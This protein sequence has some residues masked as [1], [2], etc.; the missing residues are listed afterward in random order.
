MTTPM[1][2]ATSETS[3]GTVPAS[4]ADAAPSP[5][6]VTPPVSAVD[7]KPLHLDLAPERGHIKA[8]CAKISEYVTSKLHSS[9]H[10]DNLENIGRSVKSANLINDAIP[11][12]GKPL[13]SWE[14]VLKGAPTELADYVTV[15]G[16]AVGRSLKDAA[17]RMIAASKK[18]DDG[19]MRIAG[20]DL[21][22]LDAERRHGLSNE[23]RAK[24]SGLYRSMTGEIQAAQA[25]YNEAGAS[26]MTATA[27]MDG[28]LKVDA[29]IREKFKGA[30]GANTYYGDEDLT[31]LETKGFTGL[32][33]KLVDLYQQAR[34]LVFERLVS[35]DAVKGQ[36][37][38]GIAAAAAT[39]AEE[40]RGIDQ[41]MVNVINQVKVA[42]SVVDHNRATAA[43]MTDSSLPSDVNAS[44]IVSV[45][46]TTFD[47]VKE[48]FDRKAA[49]SEKK[50]AEALPGSATKEELER[51][52]AATSSCA[53]DSRQFREMLQGI[54][55]AVQP[56]SALSDPA[57]SG[58]TREF[59][60]AVRGCKREIEKAAVAA[61]QSLPYDEA[62]KRFAVLREYSEKVAVRATAELASPDKL[63]GSEAVEIVDGLRKAIADLSRKSWV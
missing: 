33:G 3:T 56:V 57:L 34:G 52:S 38:K 15:V 17:S 45:S 14:A 11:E 16:G 29:T 22:G 44:Q 63:T 58:A 37:A 8:L 46:A 24:I 26:I 31:A 48:W 53:A 23:Q 28:L 10:L 5:A 60:A 9:R 61:M 43:C 1:T 18:L 20:C 36:D 55:R 62:I 30:V 19:L 32:S 49:D 21:A 51:L 6:P 50:L 42:A 2:V 27:A 59:T 13:Q 47:S 39:G 41:T 35:S 25:G 40:L 54:A 7:F 12:V 4:P